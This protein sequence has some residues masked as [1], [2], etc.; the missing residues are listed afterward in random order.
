MMRHLSCDPNVEVLGSAMHM[1]LINL[2]ADEVAPYLE[3]HG[4]SNIEPGEWYAFEKFLNVLNELAAGGNMMTNY[5]A[6]GMSVAGNEKSLFPPEMIASMSLADIIPT[7]GDIYTQ[8]FRGGDVGSVTT[9]RV[10][11]QHYQVIY[12]NVPLPDHLNYGGVY[13]V[14]RAFSKGAET[15]VWYDTTIQRMDEGGEETVIHVQWG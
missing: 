6:I 12:K 4:L 8:N 7:F 11:D 1:F 2:H 9:N 10:A 13:A 3:K 14:A 5:V 15:K